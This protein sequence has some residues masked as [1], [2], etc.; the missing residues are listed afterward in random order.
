MTKTGSFENVRHK[1]FKDYKTFYE[2][3]SK[4]IELAKNQTKIKC[5]DYNPENCYD[6]YYITCL[7]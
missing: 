2:V 1:N 3:A 6:E 5:E 4:N 7:P